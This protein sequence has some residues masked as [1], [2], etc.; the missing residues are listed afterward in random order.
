MNQVKTFLQ[1]R[2]LVASLIVFITVIMTQVSTINFGLS[3][4]YYRYFLTIGI[5]TFFVKV[6]YTTYFSFMKE[7]NLKNTAGLFLI[8]ITLVSQFWLLNSSLVSIEGEYYPDKTIYY[9][10]IAL[11]I[12]LLQIVI[13]GFLTLRN[14]VLFCLI[15]Y[16]AL[17]VSMY[18][19][20]FGADSNL[21]LQILSLI[22]VS[23]EFFLMFKVLALPL[24][25]KIKKQ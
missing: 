21:I 24:V 3:N 11:A 2:V 15:V 19:Y 22:V 18:R 10:F 7:I 14:S 20:R 12:Y 4:D 1:D 5:I 13:S 6:F 8:I 9:L 23:V 25:D 17:F 16:G